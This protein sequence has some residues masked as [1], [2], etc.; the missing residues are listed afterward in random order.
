MYNIFGFYMN[1]MKLFKDINTLNYKNLFKLI[2]SNL[3]IFVFN[4][5]IIKKTINFFKAKHGLTRIQMK[6]C[7]KFIWIQT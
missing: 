3:H 4:T 7:I 1:N 2:V 6:M 5:F